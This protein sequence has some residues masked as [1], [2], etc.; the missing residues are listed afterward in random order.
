MSYFENCCRSAPTWFP[1]SGLAL[2]KEDILIIDL[3]IPVLIMWKVWCVSVP[4]R[5]TKRAKLKTNTP[6][7]LELP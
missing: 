3:A 6:V 2:E 5:A 7:I 1:R 4:A